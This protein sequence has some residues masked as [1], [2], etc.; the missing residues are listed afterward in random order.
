MRRSGLPWIPPELREDRG[1]IQAAK[2]NKLPK[3]IELKD[4]KADLQT[5]SNWSDGKLTM[6]EMAQAAAKRGMKVIAFTDHSVS[7]GITNGLSMERHKEQAAEIRKTQKK[8][9][10]KI[11]ILHASEVEIKADG[12]LDYPDE[13][14]ASLDLV[15]ASLHTSLTPAAREG[16]REGDQ[17]HQ[18]PQRG[19][20]R[21]SHRTADPRPRRRRPGYGGRL[22]GRG[23]H[24]RG[25]GDQRP[26]R[27]P[28]PG[29]Y[30]CPPRQGDGH[31]DQHQHRFP[32]RGRFRH[33]VL[34]RRHR[35]PR[36][37]GEGRR[38]QLL[39]H[40][41]TAGLAEEA[42]LRGD[43]V[44]S[45]APSKTQERIKEQAISALVEVRREI[46]AAASGFSEGNSQRVFLGTWSLLDLLAHLAGWDDANRKAVREV[47]AGQ[48]PS[49]YAFRDPDWRTYNARLV[50]TYRRE[51]LSDQIAL[52]RATHLRLVETL[53]SLPADAINRDFGVR[54]RGYKVTIRRLVEADVKD[55]T[56]HLAQI[57]DFERSL[58]A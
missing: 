24:G 27:P 35:P 28:R 18:Q 9:G 10:D 16:H 14:L 55:V 49:F 2:A 34:R 17:R 8:L 23:P 25:A 32:L 19:Y 15:L 45:R 39:A 5:H 37:A 40:E 38:D 7:L 31:P 30:P 12:S 58:H 46:L 1:E 33:A 42:R 20:H 29:R 44:Q 36:L 11:L 6:L 53:R 51:R 47:M 3:L 41:E 22:P 52:V 21:P 57:R 54:F 50:E 56:A 13:F 26:P 43:A 4:I 48:V